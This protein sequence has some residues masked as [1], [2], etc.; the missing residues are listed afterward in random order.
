MTNYRRRR[1]FG[2][3]F[4][5]SVALADRRATTLTDRIDDLRAAYAA[6]RLR[7]PFRCDA[8]VVLPDHLH[9]VWTLPG[10]DYDYSTRWRHFK[11]GFTRAV[12]DDLPIKSRLSHRRKGERGLWQRRFW[13]HE[14][15]TDAD[16]RAHIEYCWLN[17]VKHG[18]VRRPIDWPYSSLHVALKRGEAEAKW[19]E[20]PKVD[21]FGDPVR[22]V[23]THP[24]P[25]AYYA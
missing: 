8:F 10:D 15:T 18:L 12:G 5:F 21:L 7:R 11:A 6:M 22:W 17:P 16:L 14:L 19:A 9:A 24:T 20:T 2:G 4:F 3:S 25:S 13:E 23:E 1:T